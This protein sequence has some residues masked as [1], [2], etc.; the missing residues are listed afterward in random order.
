M[1]GTRAAPR[2]RFGQIPSSAASSRIPTVVTADPGV[3]RDLVARVGAAVVKPVDGFAGIS[4][5]FTNSD[6]L[7]ATNPGV[8]R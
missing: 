5:G 6:D 2:A 4:G 1:V 8:D 3:V 7:V